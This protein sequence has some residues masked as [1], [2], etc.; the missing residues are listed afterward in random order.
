MF[1]VQDFRRS[2]LDVCES[3]VKERTSSDR[4]M[5]LYNYPPSLVSSGNNVDQ[6]D[7]VELI[8]ADVSFYS[9]DGKQIKVT[10]K[11]R[12]QQKKLPTLDSLK[13][14]PAPFLISHC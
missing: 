8:E 14:S 10:L 2:V 12:R 9:T 5:V 13:S 7:G 4:S 6:I 11:V 1:Q 3:S